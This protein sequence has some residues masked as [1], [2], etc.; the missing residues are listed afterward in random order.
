MHR[1]FNKDSIKLLNSKLSKGLNLV[2]P[3]L[4]VFELFFDLGLLSN[5]PENI[6]SFSLYLIWSLLF[7]MPFYLIRPR[8]INSFIRFLVND[9]INEYGGKYE[10]YNEAIKDES[11]SEKFSDINENLT[12]GYTIIQ[13]FILY[14]SYKLLV[15]HSIPENTILSVSPNITQLIICTITSVL[16]SIPVGNL[17]SNLLR[18]YVLIYFK[19]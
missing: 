5:T 15:T 10:S 4:L 9:L 11:I 6:F 17:Y 7:S 1:Y 2:V 3:G 12:F 14:F 19:E 16:I 8:S 18:K 13:L